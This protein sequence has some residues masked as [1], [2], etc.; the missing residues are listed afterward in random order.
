MARREGLASLSFR[1]LSQQLAVTPMAISYRVGSRQQ[2]LRG[3][4]EKA[5]DGVAGGFDSEPSLALLRSLLQAYCRRALADAELVQCMLADN[6]L[7]V[8]EIDSLNGII[9]QCTQRLNDGD[10][11]DV[12]FN[13]LID[14][15]HGFVLSVAVAPADAGPGIEDYLRGIDWILRR[16]RD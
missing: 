14:Y 9:R 8:S 4:I 2:L 10:E 1:S 15:T 13:L 5:F 7:I 16:C 12:L 11:H 6:R 3:L